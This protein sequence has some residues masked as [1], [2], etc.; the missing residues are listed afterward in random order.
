[1][2]NPPRWKPPTERN[3]K[4]EARFKRESWWQIT[5]PMIVVTLLM[6]GCLVGLLI[7]SGES[8]V[9]IVADYS[10][11]LLIPPM[12][13]VGVVMMAAIVGLIYLATQ[14]LGK[15]PP[16]TYTAH[17]AV[18]SIRDRVAAIAGTITGVII[19]IRAFVDGIVHFIEERFGPQAS[20]APEKPAPAEPSRPKRARKPQSP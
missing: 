3:P 13:L 1:M 4:T 14:G 2:D 7:L 10:L 20:P 16:Y 9:S 12:L 15:L 6:A 8:G 5:F 18:F 17:K 19:S 11:S